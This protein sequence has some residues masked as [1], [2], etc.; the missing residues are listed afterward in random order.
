MSRRM[1]TYY[2]TSRQPISS[3]RA[4]L[5][6]VWRANIYHTISLDYM[7]AS[8][9]V[10]SGIRERGWGRQTLSLPQYSATI[11]SQDS[12]EHDKHGHDEL[13]AN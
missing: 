5:F 2:W 12:T 3:Q 8:T 9:G 1:L 13:V 4:P 10:I 11:M 6:R 7:T